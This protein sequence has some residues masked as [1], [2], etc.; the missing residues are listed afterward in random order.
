MT[1]LRKDGVFCEGDVE[2]LTFLIR[3]TYWNKCLF[4]VLLTIV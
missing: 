4:I 3:P 2:E 1:E